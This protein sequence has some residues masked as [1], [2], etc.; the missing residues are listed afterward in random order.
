MTMITLADGRQFDTA[1]KEV[2]ESNTPDEDIQLPVPA[3]RS[4]IRLEDLPANTRVMNAVCAVAGYKLLGLN[5]NDISLA[6]GCTIEQLHEI[7]EGD[8]YSKS[9]EEMTAAFVRGQESTARDI[10]A[11]NAIV[12][13]NV[14]ATGLKSKNEANKMKA[15]ESIL[16]RNGIGGD[17]ANG[18]SGQGLV[19]KIIKDQK[20]NA[21]ITISL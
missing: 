2:V 21:G 20:D 4:G 6:L 10:L 18:M 13:A 3:P 9:L 15:A 5:N 17:T 19:I 11:K 14:L 8:I 7:L 16:N 1:K 12:A